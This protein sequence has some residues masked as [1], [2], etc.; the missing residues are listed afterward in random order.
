MLYALICTD[1]QPGGL[2]IRKETRPAH[3]EYIASLGAKVKIAGPLL[4]DDGETP[5]GSLIIVEADNIDE[6]KQLADG[7]PYAK[8]GVFETV[9][10]RAWN[11]LIGNPE[12]A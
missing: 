3:L 10:I 4:T 12:T 11:W 9:E 5:T 7:D 8:A 6:A 1:K 2:A